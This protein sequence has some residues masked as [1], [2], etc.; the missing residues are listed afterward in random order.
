[1]TDNKDLCMG[2]QFC[3]RAGG[4][5]NPVVSSADPQRKE[6]AIEVAGRCPF[7]RLVIREKDGIPVEPF[8]EKSI[9]VTEDP[10]KEVSGPLWVKGGLP[11]ESAEGHVYEVRNRVT[12]CDAVNRRSNRYATGPTRS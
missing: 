9:S 3:H 10:G 5:R 11:I 1:M 4:V 8:F 7:G 2:A 12:L 6:L